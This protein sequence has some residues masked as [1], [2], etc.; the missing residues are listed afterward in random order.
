MTTSPTPDP[1]AVL[2]VTR[3]ATDDDLDRAF[4]SAV[5]QLHPDTRTPSELDAD[6][7]RRLQ[8]LLTAYATLRD[9]I[10]R[11]AYER[12]RP[13]TASDGA[14]VRPRVRHAPR[15]PAA[16]RV[17]AALRV[18]SVHWDPLPTTTDGSSG[19][20]GSGRTREAHDGR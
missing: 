9:P 5:R 18:G 1:Y 20:V 10:R 4:R 14:T 19:V 11:A 8:E 2:G 13:A 16:V 7:D 6:A 12:S 15:G 17:G 3:D